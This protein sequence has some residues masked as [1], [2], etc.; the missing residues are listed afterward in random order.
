MKQE[1]AKLQDNNDALKTQLK[2]LAVDNETLQTG[3][4]KV[5]HENSSLKDQVDVLNSLVET[6]QT[7]EVKINGLITELT[8]KV[9]TNTV[10]KELKVQLS[11]L[12]TLQTE[13][14]S[15]IDAIANRLNALETASQQSSTTSAPPPAEEQ[16]T[17]QAAAG[18]FAYFTNEADEKLFSEKVAE[19][20]TLDM[21]YAQIDNHLTKSLPKDLDTIVKDHPTL[22]K[23]YIRSVRNSKAD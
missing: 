8:T 15:E 18:I 16:V 4:N 17:E 20:V 11:K 6:L 21:T 19:A 1:I 14:R 5:E 2:G 22:T 3:L 9:E 13:T 23:T 10:D 12:E 7:S